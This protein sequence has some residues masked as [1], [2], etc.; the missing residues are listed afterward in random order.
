MLEEL[1][2][3]DFQCH[4][5]MRVQFDPHITAIVG[6]SDVGKSSL[7]RALRWVS[8]NRP[9]G[10]SFIREDSGGC[11]VGLKVDGKKVTRQRG[12]SDNKYT[13]GNKEFRA[14]GTDVPEPI[15]SLLNLGE[16]NF[17][18]QH[19]APYWFDLSAGEVARR[20]N[21]I[22]DLSAIDD[23]LMR[24]SALLRQAN[25]VVKVTKSRLGVAR[26]NR[27]KLGFVLA[28]N[29]ELKGVERTQ[30]AIGEARVKQIKLE[31]YID[32]VKEAKRKAELT[33]PDFSPLKSM[34]K[35]LVKMVETK[36][37]LWRLVGRARV[38]TE[39]VDKLKAELA[40]K[41]KAFK[42]EVGDTCPLCGSQMK[43]KNNESRR[44]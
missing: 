11:W 24:L 25:S 5:K 31:H 6:P 37:Q 21:E 30:D 23:V 4:E 27:K 28:M 20:L 40:R 35:Q 39:K 38:R 36:N 10:D 2:I 8:M 18:G 26:E 19:S 14:F 12:K 44:T 42:L 9:T 3:K 41:M 29:A 7:L 22:V 1:R 15:T 34:R 17:Q 13:L 16:V 32:D 43:E 33:V